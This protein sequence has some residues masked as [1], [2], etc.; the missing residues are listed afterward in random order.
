MAAT[1]I[2]EIEPR[3]AEKLTASLKS[4]L[5]ELRYHL[6]ENYEPRI[7]L[8]DANR[9]KKRSNASADHWSPESGRIEIRFEP[10]RTE[11]RAGVAG[12]IAQSQS[13]HKPSQTEG[14][15]DQDQAQPELLKHLIKSL[16]SAE[17]RPGWNFVPLRKF[18][19][20]IFPAE[21]TSST[22]VERRSVLRCA[23]DK[24]LILIGK[25]ENP[26]APAF[27]VTTIRLNRLNSE[28]QNLLGTSHYQSLDFHPVRIT[29]EPLSATIL[30]ERR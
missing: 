25:V 6:P 19:D 12:A 2:E 1:K 16:D 5:A 26:K 21:H 7:S 22:D 27:P 30:R 8:L 24:K 9:R 17:S 14:D 15:L 4:V 3:I 18:R 11:T 28:V 23:I 29:G 20:E 10:S 13:P